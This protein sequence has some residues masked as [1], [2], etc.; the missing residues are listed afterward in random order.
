MDIDVY[1]FP[2]RHDVMIL[3]ANYLEQRGWFLIMG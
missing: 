1:S 3:N 2:H